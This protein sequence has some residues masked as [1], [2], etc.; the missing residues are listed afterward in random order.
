M[1]T[2]TRWEPLTPRSMVGIGGI[3]FFGGL[4]GF[5]I[6]DPATGAMWRLPDSY[7]ANLSEKVKTLGD[8]S[9][10]FRVLSINDIPLEERATLIPVK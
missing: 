5:L 7:H 2:K 3:S 6:V 4:I 8:A 1:D 10:S 9:H